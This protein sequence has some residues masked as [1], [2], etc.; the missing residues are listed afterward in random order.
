[1]TDL[2]TTPRAAGPIDFATFG[3][4]SGGSARV[5]IPESSGEFVRPRYRFQG[6]ISADPSAEFPAAPGRYH[7]Y[8]SWAC[9]WAHRSAI[10]RSLKGLEDVVSMS[11]VDPIR[12]ARGWAFRDGDGHGLDDVNGYERTEPGYDGHVSVPVLWDRVSDRIVSN[13]FPD[14][15]LDLGTAFTEWA[16]PSYDLYPVALRNEIDTLNDYLYAGLNNGVYRAGFAG[17]QT[18]YERAVAEVFRCLDALESRLDDRPFLLGESVTESD[19][20]AYVTLARFDCVYYSHFKVN[21]RRITDYP[22]LWR[23]ARALYRIPAFATTTRFDQIKR[24]Y[25]MTHPQ[26]NPNR[27]VPVGPDLSWSDAS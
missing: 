16:D 27:I 14:I 15:S 20:R 24:H 9:P 19:V 21:I 6:R 25:Y 5:G 10:V 3:D 13:N 8:V 17:S 23:Y 4:Y 26:L 11:V 7:L 2:Q 18:E 1:M 22:N 12:D